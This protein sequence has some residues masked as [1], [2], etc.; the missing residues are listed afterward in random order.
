MPTRN[1]VLTEQQAIFVGQLV[2]TGRYQNAS[3]VL[4]DGLRL[5][6]DRVKRREA[7][8]ADISAGV[9][10]GFDQ[11]ERGEFA[12]GSGEEAIERAFARAVRKHGP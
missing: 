7:E 9:I 11:I 5:L 1:V 10:A 12:E 3:E 8:L 2:E 4:R 6:E